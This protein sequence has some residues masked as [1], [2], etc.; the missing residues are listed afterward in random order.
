MI[1]RRVDQRTI[2]A[3]GYTSAF[4]HLLELTRE[5]GRDDRVSSSGHP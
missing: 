5:R 3:L 2:N 1:L 4:T